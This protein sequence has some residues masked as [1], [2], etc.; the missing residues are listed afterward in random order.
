MAIKSGDYEFVN[1]SPV[2][3]HCKNACLLA[4]GPK[5]Y[6]I[7]IPR[8]NICAAPMGAGVNVVNPPTS[9]SCVSTTNENVEQKV[10]HVV[11]EQKIA[12]PTVQEIIHQINDSDDEES[13]T[14]ELTK[15]SRASVT[16][17]N[18]VAIGVSNEVV[19][20]T[21]L[22]PKDSS[23]KVASFVEFE[24]V[25]DDT[26][27]IGDHV[28]KRIAEKMAWKHPGVILVHEVT[29]HPFR[30]SR[31]KDVRVPGDKI[32]KKD[33]SLVRYVDCDI[34]VTIVPYPAAVRAWLWFMSLFT[35]FTVGF[36]TVA[37][38]AGVDLTVF[39]EMLWFIL[40]NAAHVNLR[41]ILL[42]SSVVLLFT[43]IILFWLFNEK[44]TLTYRVCPIMLTHLR[45]RIDPATNLSGV[46][47]QASSHLR[48]LSQ[49]NVPNSLYTD[50]LNGTMEYYMILHE[51]YLNSPGVAVRATHPNSSQRVF[52]SANQL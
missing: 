13:E 10:Q 48:C 38:A 19:D 4:R 41:G 29:L 33:E 45:S 26:D 51:D 17:V 34:T 1:D 39:S 25:D 42:G 31:T 40:L 5:V 15:P 3:K 22:L 2:C 18:A 35:V 23:P 44:T 6:H 50:V 11:E 8:D 28:Q 12:V 20:S 9:T 16:P 27:Y 7:R 52:A 37:F 21:V 47:Q 46:R 14:V 43:V 24:I 36:K 30:C 32:S 49:L